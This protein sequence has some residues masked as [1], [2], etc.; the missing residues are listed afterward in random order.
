MALRLDSRL[1]YVSWR[2]H[3]WHGI[4]VQRRFL[5]DCYRLWVW[6]P[7]LHLQ[8]FHPCSHRLNSVGI[9][10]MT[11]PLSGWQQKL[12]ALLGTSG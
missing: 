8:A 10:E 6:V 12:F 9:R 2:L 1:D 11:I 3:L 4:R 7:M 5:R